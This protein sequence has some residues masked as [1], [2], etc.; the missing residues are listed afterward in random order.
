MEGQ[1][2]TH[3]EKLFM[4]EY[5][6]IGIRS[7]SNPHTSFALFLL[8]DVGDNMLFLH[9]H[10]KGS[11]IIIIQFLQLRKHRSQIISI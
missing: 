5:G 3:K 8:G 1:K 4:E 10:K 11:V 9:G 7:C 2:W 6:A